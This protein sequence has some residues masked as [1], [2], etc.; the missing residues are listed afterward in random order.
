MINNRHADPQVLTIAPDE[1]LRQVANE[2][3]IETITGQAT[4]IKAGVLGTES[5]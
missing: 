5:S 1:S 4:A 2:T 3:T